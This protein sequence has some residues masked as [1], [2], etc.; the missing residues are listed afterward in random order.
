MRIETPKA[1]GRLV[2][3]ARMRGLAR[4][5]EPGARAEPILERV[6]LAKTSAGGPRAWVH[7]S[8]FALLFEDGSAVRVTLPRGEH[9]LRFEGAEEASRGTWEELHGLTSASALPKESAPPFAQVEV[10]TRQVRDGDTVEVFGTPGLGGEVLRARIV[11]CGP[12]AAKAMEKA[13]REE[14]PPL[15]VKVEKRPSGLEEAELDL[16]MWW[17]TGLPIVLMGLG[18]AVHAAG[19][20]GPLAP[21]SAAEKSALAALG[22]LSLAIAGRPSRDPCPF[23]LRARPYSRVVATGAF[24]VLIAPVIAFAILEDLYL[25]SN[26]LTPRTAAVVVAVMLAV[27][28]LVNL[29]TYRRFSALL[30]GPRLDRSTPEGAWC[31]G[32]GEVLDETPVLLGG[33]SAL[34]AIETYQQGA[35]D[36]D[37]N[38]LLGRQFEAEGSFQIRTEH[39][40]LEV[41]P[42]EILWSTTVAHYPGGDASPLERFSFQY[43]VPVGGKVLFAGRLAA[44]QTEGGLRRLRH[45]G[46]RPALLF[47]MGSKGAPRALLRRLL[48]HR[49]LT[50]L[51]LACVLAGAVGLWK[52]TGG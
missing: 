40:V 45:A 43:S 28:L 39:E 33:Q 24:G 16:S 50:S 23:R 19:F 27:H 22:F 7:R 51:G 21:G 4:A 2:G 3:M 10:H 17:W 35:D 18:F 31:T 36:E 1:G 25:Y 46:T 37:E 34:G 13:V 26:W 14:F 38:K 20:A 11:T 15:Q 49:R 6:M 48:W 5:L 9:A 12:D 32:E 29:G 41:D 47:A 30:G 52:A 8:D 44:P 42:A